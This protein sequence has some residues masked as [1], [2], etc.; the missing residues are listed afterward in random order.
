VYTAADG[1]VFIFEAKGGKTFI[2]PMSLS[3]DGRIVTV[4]NQKFF[5]AQGHPE[6]IKSVIEAMRKSKLKQLRDAADE[7]ELAWSQGKLSYHFVSSTWMD[8][9]ARLVR[10]PALVWTANPTTRI[11]TVNLPQLVL[12]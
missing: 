8:S 12:P 1:R 10:S 6:Y 9:S 2:Q 11:T 4:G 7:V 5:A 3:P